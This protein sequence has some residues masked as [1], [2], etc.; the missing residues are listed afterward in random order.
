[1]NAL[2]REGDTTWRNQNRSSKAP[3]VVYAPAI[4]MRNRLARIESPFV[5][6][7]AEQSHGWRVSHSPSD[8]DTLAVADT[9]HVSSEPSLVVGDPVE[10]TKQLIRLTF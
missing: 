9:P 3:F 4:D 1:M 5:S 6:M 10:H 8:L 2:Y 7:L